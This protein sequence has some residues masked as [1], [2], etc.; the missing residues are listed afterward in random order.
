MCAL[1]AGIHSGTYSVRFQVPQ[2]KSIELGVFSSL[3]FLG[4]STIMAPPSLG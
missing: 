2:P 4:A 1:N 3:S